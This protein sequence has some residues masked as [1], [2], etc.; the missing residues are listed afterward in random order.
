MPGLGTLYGRGGATTFLQDLR[1]ADLIIIQ[2]SNFAENHPVGFRFVTEAKDRGATVVHVDPRFTRTSALADLYIPIRSGSDIAFT[3]G[4]INYVLQRDVYF[5]EY[6]LHYTNASFIVDPDFRD[7]EDL[8]G[9]FSGFDPATGKYD[10]STWKYELEG[11]P[12]GEQ[13]DPQPGAMSEAA[14]TTGA[15]PA[16]AGHRPKRDMTLQHPRCVINVMKRHFARYTPEM[17]E[18]ITGSPQESFR[19]LCELVVENSGRERTMTYCY[20]M[21]W[22]QHTTGVQN[23]RAAATLQALMG[24]TGRPGGGVLALRGH[25]SIQGSTDIP[26]LYDLLPGYI[27]APSF[28]RG[29]DSFAKWRDNWTIH[30]GWWSNWPKYAVSLMKAW[31]GDAARADNDW[32]FDYL[33][34]N[35]GDH[36]HQAMFYAMKDGDVEGLILWGQN[37]AVGGQNAGL[38][39]AAMG[40]L[41]W[42]VVRDIFETES[43]AFWKREGVRPEEIGTEVF[44]MPAAAIAEKAGTLTQTMRYVQFH[45]KA[46]DAPNDARSDL[47][48]CYQLGLRL[49][50]LYA[51]SSRAIDRPLLDMTWDYESDDPH[52]RDLGECDPE[53]VMREINGYHVETGKHLRGFAEC[54]DDGSTACGCW[55]YSGYFPEP[56]NNLTRRRHGD[57]LASLE[58]A[59]AWPA[60][61]RMLYNR[62]SADP[63]GKPWSERK[64]WVW[65]DEATQQWTGHDVPDFILDRSPAFRGD[66]AAPGMAAHDGDA[67]FIMQEFGVAEIFGV[68]GA[69]DGPFPTFYEARESPVGNAL[70]P[71]VQSNPVLK[72]WRRRDNPYHGTGDPKYPYVV[73]TYRLTEHHLS[74][75][76]TRWL[77]WLAELQPELFV[78]LSPELAVERGVRN[79]DWVTVET[80]RATIEA[81]ALV[82]GRL[83]PFKLG[84]GRWVHQIG[85]PMHFGPQGLVNGDSANDLPPNVAD[86]NVSIHEAKAFTCNL[87]LGRRSTRESATA[88]MRDVPP[89]ERTPFGTPERLGVVV[90]PEGDSADVM[91]RTIAPET[92]DA[93][94][95]V[96]HAADEGAR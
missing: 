59:F 96:K 39:R 10:T 70:Y 50:A 12:S 48:F 46:V 84:K 1:N 36:S 74:G 27:E 55:I 30:S 47:G 35:T 20:A 41:K 88:T 9:L 66:P 19:K 14:Q 23:I 4:I 26:T 92:I 15:H 51:R 38:Q 65:W 82:T 40:K 11:A 76:M 67:P 52:E 94:A 95:R 28:D 63:A 85:I 75:V 93:G 7:T 33:P 5:K 43:A 79:G 3:G 78:E 44:F 89:E 64:K 37:P 61:R 54:Q 18:R 21:G 81:K 32:A 58:W 22:A 69:V 45:D 2:G 31:Y 87:R 8:E 56:G 34:K 6:V 62:A 86:P 17:V 25:A 71:G 13:A 60:N 73:T 16:H 68:Q 90:A 91:R 80:A 57:D 42:L 53:K 72:E 24:N 83:A 29:E 49:K 77:P